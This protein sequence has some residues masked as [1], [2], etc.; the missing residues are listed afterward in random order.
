MI[1]MFRRLRTRTAAFVH[2]LCWV[3]V[4]WLGAFFL[5]FNLDA[6][7]PLYFE[8]AIRLLPVVIAVHGAV[9]WQQ[10]L[11][12]GVWRF[13]S[14]P[15]LVR[16]VQAVVIGVAIT[17]V[18]IFLWTR[19]F[20]LPR[21]VLVLQALLL[22]AFL[23]GP[24]L[25]YRWLKD[26]RFVTANAKRVLVVGAGAAGETLV[27]DLKRDRNSG[28]VPVGFV[29]DDETKRGME[30]HGVR[31]LA[32]TGRI[33][34][35]V[36]DLD[37]DLIVL[38]IPSATPAARRTIVGHCEDAQ[39][40]VR[41]MPEMGEL[42]SGQADALD[43]RV[44]SIEDLLGREAVALDW[45]Q[46][47]E[48]ITDRTVL[49]TGGAGSIG[50]ELCRQLARLKPKQ[51]VVVDQ[52]EYGLYTADSELRAHYEDL[53]LAVYL[54]DVCDRPAMDEL[55]SRVKPEIVF[56]AAAYK[57]VPLLEDQ[58]REAVRN[59]VLGTRTVAECA[60]KAK[61]AAVVLIS[62]DKAVNPTNVM[63]ATKR[64]AEIYC[65]NAN[66]YA[67]E[68][69]FVTVRFGNVLG[70]AGSVVP[71]FRQQI[72]DGGPIT[73]T[74][75]DIER[76]FMTI[77]EATQLILQAG[78]E[79]KGGEIFV[80]DMGEPV[81]IVYLA[82]QM[83]SMA[84]F[85]PREDIDIVFSGL[86]PGEKLYEELFHESEQLSAT[87]HEKLLLAR[88]RSVDWNAFNASLD[89]LLA[90]CDAYDEQALRRSVVDLVPDYRATEG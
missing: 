66:Q 11:Y 18:V 39:I 13:A 83:I 14:L 75:P 57:H 69:R 48:G 62:T 86:R 24:R 47:R 12:R 51:L 41:T 32:K 50:T 82:E 76:Y 45:K 23:S 49:V 17:G 27:R 4:S 81:K 35:V 58:V 31:V 89:A 68:T 64:L 84:G 43:L 60:V 79:G 19:M 54:R 55:F 37:I 21:S 63:G 77:S 74:H 15:D 59:N 42:M 8:Q 16:I 33:P 72:S 73:V 7:P 10:G 20:A 30:I 46:I 25:L 44:L 67:A 34:R 5:R 6:I 29:D 26:R 53:D 52:S 22:I 61:T 56:H 70:S 2:D 80:L 36:E 40:P 90:N 65:Q 88:F 78:A 28:Y 3:P 87:N 85:R 9:F 71:K 38:A 1:R